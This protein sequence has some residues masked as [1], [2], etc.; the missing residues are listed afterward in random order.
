MMSEFS[1]VQSY[2]VSSDTRILEISDPE[3][4]VAC[5]S[6]DNNDQVEVLTFG[7]RLFGLQTVLEQIVEFTIRTVEVNQVA[8]AH[9]QA[10]GPS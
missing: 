7:S 6:I 3:E 5:I 1:F 4:C 8:R 9:D 2:D 10:D